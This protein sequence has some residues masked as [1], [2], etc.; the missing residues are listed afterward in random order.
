MTSVVVENS[1]GK[2]KNNHHV[3]SFYPTLILL[4][5]YWTFIKFLFTNIDLYHSLLGYK[6]TVISIENEPVAIM[7]SEGDFVAC[8]EVEF[9][10]GNRV[11]TGISG[12]CVEKLGLEDKIDHTEKVPCL[13]VG[14]SGCRT[15]IE[16][17]TVEIQIEIR[18]M[19]FTLKAL[20]DVSVDKDL[21][22]GMDVID[23]LFDGNYT[24]GK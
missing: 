5:L 12:K 20:Y 9:D 23:S 11:L 1:S 2:G 21:L 17:S 15:R 24:L 22:I 8:P 4:A 19:V 10:T 16:F 18:G 3:H 13:T 6:P 7:N 14:K